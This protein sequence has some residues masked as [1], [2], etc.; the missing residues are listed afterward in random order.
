MYKEFGP[1]SWSINNKT[2]IYILTI[3]IVLFGVVSYVNLP[4][5][6]F[7]D[8]VIPTIYVQTIQAG[9]SP[10]DMENIVT[11]KLEKQIKAASGVKKI[12]SIS[13]QDFSIVVVEF[14][15]DVPVEIA[16]Q[17]IKDR[18]D[19][20]RPELPVT[21]TKE[22]QVTEVNF[23]DIPIMFVNISGDYPLDKLKK[24][25]DVAKEKIEGMKEI[26]RVDMVGALDR[27]MQVDVDL[28]KMNLAQL[29]M[30]DIERA[31]DYENRIISGGNVKVQD[32][33]RTVS[34]KGEFKSEE[35]VK[36]IVVQSINGSPIY[37]KDI[38]NVKYS[39]K[40]QES[41]A[42]LDRK[43]VITLNVVKRAGENLIEA[44]DKIRNIMKDLEA[45][46]YP[47]DLKV[48]ITG[49]QS[50][51]TRTTLNDLINT[52][53]IGFILVTLVLMF[54]MGTTN[55]LFVGLSVPISTF[56]AF[57]V[58]PTIDFSLNMIVLFAFLFA[59]GI[60]V[61][62]AIVVIENTHRIFHEENLS[63]VDSAKKA[64]G[65]VFVPV[66]AGTLTTLAP[67]IPLAFLPGIV[68][69]FMFFLPVTL[70]ITLLASLFV[71]F[72]IN[73]V[74]AVSFMRKEKVFTH[75]ASFYEKNRILI[76]VSLSLG[77][78]SL[79]L[80][81]AGRG[82]GNFGFILIVILW[83]NKFLFTPLIKG[84]QHKFWPKVVNRYDKLI[85]YVLVGYRPAFMI[86]ITVCLFFISQFLFIASSPKVLFFPTADPNFAYTYI[87]MP[88]GTDQTVTDS[89][90]RLVENKVF[91]V[92]GENNPIVESVISNVTIGV[93]EPSDPDRSPQPHK[94]KVSVAFV[95]FAKRNGVSTSE[96]MEKIRNA[97]KEVKV[98]GAQISVSQE[99]NGPP[100]GPPISVEISGDDF[101]ELADIS[102][103]FIRYIDSIDIPG[104]EKFKS[105]LV[106][107]KPEIIIEIDRERANRE[108]ISTAQIGMEI[109]SAIFGKELS[110]KFRDGEDENPIM[111]RYD[112]SQRSKIDEV[113]NM[114]ITYRD[115]ALGGAIRQVP[116]SSVAKVKF[117]NTYGA[118][119]RK[120][121]KRM[122][123]I[124]SNVLKDYSPNDIVPK[125]EKAIPG[126]KI[127][128][129]YDIKI[130]GEQEE[131]NE[132]SQYLMFSLL[133]SI[134]MIFSILVTQFNSISKPIIILTE[135]FF[136]IIG[137]LLGYTIF[138]MDFVIIMTGIGIVGLAGI[139][140]KNGILIVE[141]ADELRGRG[142]ELYDAL[143]MAGRTRMTPVL[144]T[145]ISTIL[146][147][148][149][150]AI[151]FN[152]N[153]A[154]L[155]SDFDPQLHIGG[156]SVAFWGPLSWT[157]IFGLAFATFL[158][159][160]LVPCMYFISEGWKQKLKDKKIKKIAL[161][162][163][164]VL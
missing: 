57:L 37:I 86:V 45:N 156:D 16:K 43:N 146:G 130:G 22:P 138:R 82:F 151:G 107:K 68:G 113:M 159:L 7:P 49:D 55:A 81:G 53:I 9:T 70:I 74:F 89:V 44:S 143:V 31:L 26:T 36:N 18:V 28:Y 8:I 153:F 87:T 2:S 116:V 59:L 96:I 102:T 84:F 148:I 160:V 58:M 152:I 125:I 67:F 132:T 157:I 33:K 147:L 11:R 69:K 93:N 131:Q 88:I 3:I 76:I 61:D 161:E 150:L 4:K 158:T 38:A 162:K 144:Q 24:F 139:V 117:S 41:Y 6:N 124:N 149:P 105:D 133:V 62:D 73:P 23:S 40:E 46:K 32:M 15:A 56:I 97:M 52:I 118:I 91:E 14:N 136:S 25:A 140:V 119:K 141:F 90:S 164:G 5:E 54:F 60:V 98:P 80:Y 13:L 111:V 101:M 17:R 120:N 127:P 154:T 72:I 48:V 35:D 134:L 20:A 30:G 163:A 94:A 64:A 34:I 39:F 19:A 21:L 65:E 79:L 83:M 126:F 27:E 78:L 63:I 51:E 108:G 109:R 1:T 114:N 128:D 129:G 121:Q 142:M 71:A 77:L 66:L 137:V 47:S 100:T 106:D 103:R 110:T 10:E 92:I 155:I 50:K 75:D 99:Q 135:I 145:A 85:R 115:M 95:E 112:V 12:N 122:V 123:T 42:R 104:I 29:T